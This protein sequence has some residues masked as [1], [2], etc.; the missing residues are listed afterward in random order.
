MIT[1]YSY[2]NCDTC[3]RALKWLVFH[4]INHEVKPIRET[5]PSKS[6]LKR[7]LKAK[8]GEIKKLFNSSGSDYKALG[9]KDKLPKM[10]NSEAIDLLAGNGRLVKR[11][12]VVTDDAVLI[13]FKEKEWEETLTNQS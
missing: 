10:S 2:K 13:G 9:L 4:N 11:P 8:N 3:R 1:V 12:F 5:P 7:A 6:E